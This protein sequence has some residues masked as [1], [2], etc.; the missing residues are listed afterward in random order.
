MIKTDDYVEFLKDFYNVDI[1]VERFKHLLEVVNL[2]LVKLEIWDKVRID[3]KSL[4]M[5]VLDYYVDIVRMRAFQDIEKPNV[6]KVYGYTMYWFLR[7]HPIHVI[8]EFLG[9]ESINEKFVISYIS[10]CILS[11]ENIS[12]DDC[13]NIL[14]EFIKLLFYNLKYRLYTQQSMEL[15]INAFFCGCKLGRQAQITAEIKKLTDLPGG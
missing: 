15:M 3:T 13:K 7:R 14:S 5:A 8:T 6:E 10:S 11:D 1:L 9:C 4:K 2:F 12:Y